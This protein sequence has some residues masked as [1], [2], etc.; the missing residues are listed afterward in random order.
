[1][2]TPLTLKR[3]SANRPSGAMARCRLRRAGEWRRRLPHLLPRRGCPGGSSVDVGEWAQRTHQ[4]RSTRLEEAM[5]AF[6]KS[7]RR[8]T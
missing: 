8:A 7:W 2:A 3:G 5:A 6:A 4:A 1:M